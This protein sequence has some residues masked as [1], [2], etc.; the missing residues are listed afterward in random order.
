MTAL[1][2][3]EVVKLE[4]GLHR[5]LAEPRTLSF[6]VDLA[7]RRGEP[8][9]LVGGFLRDALLGQSSDEVDLVARR[10][11]ELA[12]ACSGEHGARLVEIDR[13]FGALRLIPPGAERGGP[14]RSV[15]LSP[16]RGSSIL[17]DLRYRDFTVN[18]MA[19]EL[20]AWRNKGRVEF[21]DPLDGL[22]DLRS[23]QLRACTS[24]TFADDP[25]RVLRAYRF[26][27][28]YPFKLE[29]R[30]GALMKEGGP[31]LGHV[32][33][34][35]V[36]DELSLILETPSSARILK[37]LDEDGVVPFLLP[38][39]EPMRGLEQNGYHHLDVWTH[40]LLTLEALEDLM[41]RMD[42]LF[43]E[44]V[45]EVSAILGE[46]LAGDRT[47][48]GVLKLAA[49]LH[50]VAKPTCRKVGEKGAVHFYGHEVAGARLA[51]SICSRLRFS[52]QEIQEVAELVRQHMRLGHLLRL[53]PPSFRSLSRFFRLG[54]VV[55]WP[56][57]LLA[58]ADYGAARGPL[59]PGW[60]LARF[61]RHVGHWLG[62]YRRELR[63]REA[64]PALVSGHDLMEALNL[65]PGPL[66]GRLLRAVS[67]L[68]WEGRLSSPEEALRE[69]SRLLA[70]WS[71][72]ERQSGASHS[73]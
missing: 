70:R 37:L 73:P 19:V 21:I 38:E 10:A 64:V 28:F 57:F 26:L 2:R 59:S 18:A 8:L 55:F 24:L 15:D 9:Y 1:H 51:A 45:R 68:Q 5:L 67:D 16:L 61:N 6:L 60:D 31:G 58:A 32:A 40:C 50:D 44:S 42:L 13:R 41:D 47:R 54:P 12:A 49:L 35:R 22:A 33:V 63:P 65:S 36:R 34:E 48:S 46:T 52:N 53:D 62:F 17:V 56:L 14:I 29:L 11:S 39:C 43:T 20:L 25:L 30:T 4:A 69:A 27:A 72:R 66:V 7:A 23:G 71:G 3:D